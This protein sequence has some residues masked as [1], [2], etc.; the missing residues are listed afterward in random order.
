VQ[1][2]YFKSKTEG[3]TLPSNVPISQTALYSG[4]FPDL[5][6]LSVYLQ[7]HTDE[8]EREH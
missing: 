1:L 3:N 7:Q 8:D 2:K 5:G 4:K 6:R